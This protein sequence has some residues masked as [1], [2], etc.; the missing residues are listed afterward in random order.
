MPRP[1]RSA[2]ALG[3][4]VLGLLAA[5][6]PSVA[7]LPPDLLPSYGL[8]AVEPPVV[9]A[10]FELP[11]LGGGRA[12][13]ADFRGRWVVLT[14]WATWCGPCRAE[15]PSLERLQRQRGEAGLIVL[16]VSVDTGRKSAAAF[17]EELGLSFPNL[18]DERGAVGR[19]YQATSI[20]LSYLID[21]QGRVVSLARG[22]RDWSKLVPLADGL[23]AAVPPRLGDEAAR[24]AQAPSATGAGVAPVALPPVFDP[25]TAEVALL[26]PAPV[27]GRPF[28]LEVRLRWA[29]DLAE[30][31]P[32][33][34]LVHLP[35]G[36]ERL[37]VTAATSS[38]G[39]GSRQ[40]GGRGEKGGRSGSLVTYRLE[41]RAAEPGSYALD[42]VELRYTPR[43]ETAAMASRVAGPTVEVGGR[44]Q[45]AA[46][47]AAV[48]GAGLI[49]LLSLLA[50]RRA[51]RPAAE[52]GSLL[53]PAALDRR[54]EEARRLRL[55]GE[56]GAALRVL[57]EL[58]DLLGESAAETEGE[59]AE[60]LERA[61]FGG[62]PPAGEALTRIERRAARAIEARRP[63]PR[64]EARRR[65]RLRHRES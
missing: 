32:Q 1:A 27:A 63:D 14:F 29:G 33:P 16:G 11:R 36:V 24:I 18:W 45:P 5:A 13:L 62:Q 57:A 21:P 60:M 26:D 51:R 52:G 17:V 20:P 47:P 37:A 25:P 50:V 19:A 7:A 58:L 43:L 2:A 41:L 39:E 35:E 59:L 55:G 42:P 48:A 49:G 23:L 64:R 34:P 4:A 3:T 6:G 40:E 61:R 53:E 28:E 9:A 56:P 46:V 30:Y 12:A 22:A 38:R 15:M 31:L 54:L 65:L 8:R 10:D 44:R